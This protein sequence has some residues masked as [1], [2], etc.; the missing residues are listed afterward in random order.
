MFYWD[1]F[2]TF[3]KLVDYLDDDDISVIK[4]KPLLNI[5]VVKCGLAFL[6]LHLSVLPTKITNLEHCNSQLITQ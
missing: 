4:L 3:K 2:W 1:H 6:K 5:N